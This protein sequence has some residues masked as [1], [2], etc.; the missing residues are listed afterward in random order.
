LSASQHHYAA[1]NV[2][3]RGPIATERNPVS[4]TKRPDNLTF[5]RDD[6]EQITYILARLEHFLILGDEHTAL[7]VTHYLVGDESA[8]WLAIWVAELRTKLRRQ[9]SPR[10]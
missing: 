3:W 1:V 4:R 2:D 9:L 10:P 7:Q 5:T 8:E 6:V